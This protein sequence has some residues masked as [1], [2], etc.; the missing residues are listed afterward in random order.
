MSLLYSLC[1]N[2]VCNVACFDMTV[3]MCS[4][5]QTFK[6]IESVSRALCECL[7]ACVWKVLL[8]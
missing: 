7:K 5:I 6:M 2:A 3:K 8:F 4:K 1:H